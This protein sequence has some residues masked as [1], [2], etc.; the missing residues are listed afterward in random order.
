MAGYR[1]APKAAKA[2]RNP[3]Q[4][5]R[6]AFTVS[7]GNYTRTADDT[8]TITDVAAVTALSTSLTASDTI[9]ITDTA[10]H[11]G[12]GSGSTAQ[13]GLVWLFAPSGSTTIL[14]AATDSVTITDTASG[15]VSTASSYSRSA[16]DT[17]TLTDVA[18]GVYRLAGLRIV[19]DTY[20]DLAASS[21]TVDLAASV[22]TV[23]VS[24]SSDVE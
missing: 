5:R 2:R 21:T 8:L 4:R 17:V 3:R 1:L 18:V 23:T 14:R 15:S 10:S 11:S 13:G 6:L 7:V 9:T 20:I 22:S 12:L 24:D 19:R 16:T